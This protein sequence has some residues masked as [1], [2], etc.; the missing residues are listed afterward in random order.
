MFLKIDGIK[1]ESKDSKHGGEIDI[2]S[3]SWGVSNTGT[4]ALAGGAG[5]GHSDHQDVSFT[6]FYDSSSPELMASCATGKHIPKAWLVCRKAGGKQEE[7]I[8]IDFE[9]LIISSVGGGGHFDEHDR[10]LENVS[11]NFRKYKVEYY[12]QDE[13]GAVKKAGQHTYELDKK[14]K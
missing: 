1:G 4:F 5:G 10:M 9:D 14:T 3:W 11:F 7:F 8:K 13:K 12:A 2:I 6:H